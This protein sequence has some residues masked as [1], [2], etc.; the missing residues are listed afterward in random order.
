[1]SSWPQA[2]GRGGCETAQHALTR[3]GIT[4]RQ[5]RSRRSA[6]RIRLVQRPSPKPHRRVAVKIADHAA[7]PQ[8]LP[9]HH[10]QSV[11]DP[12]QQFEQLVLRL[13]ALPR[14]TAKVTKDHRNVRLPR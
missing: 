10:S 11:T 13:L 9:G 14:K 6:D 7:L 12:L 4:D 5:R 8:Y 1:A 3:K 2:C